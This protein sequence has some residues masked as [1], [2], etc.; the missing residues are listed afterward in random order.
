MTVNPISLE[1]LKAPKQKRE[2]YGHR[3]TIPPEKIDMLFNLVADGDSLKLAAKKIGLCYTTAKK[4]FDEGDKKRGIKPLKVRLELFQEKISEKL[5]SIAE[6][7]R[8]DRLTS[9]SKSVK[10]MEEKMFGKEVSKDGIIMMEGGEFPEFDF[11]DYERMIKL[12]MYLMGGVKSKDSET[13][14]LTAEE[15]SG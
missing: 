11:K 3:Y 5:N 7:Q 15:I 6:E 10:L 13:K 1:N 2:G 4:Y 8:L 14:M 12:Q 9:V